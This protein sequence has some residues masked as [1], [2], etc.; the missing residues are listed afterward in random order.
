MP[1]NRSLSRQ[2]LERIKGYVDIVSLDDAPPTLPHGKGFEP[3]KWIG[4]YIK[5]SNDMDLIQW[6][7]NT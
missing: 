7:S 2:G 3:F 1:I 6:Q 4:W 5:P